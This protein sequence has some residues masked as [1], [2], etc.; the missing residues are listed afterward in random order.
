MSNLIRKLVSHNRRRY[1]DEDFNLDLSYVTDNVI[2]M[3][4]PAPVGSKRSLIRNK[5]SQVR[6]FL[7]QNHP[8][9]YKVR[10]RVFAWF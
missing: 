3:A 10:S 7:D 1:V 8:E 9:V 4:F 5:G 6:C 2:A